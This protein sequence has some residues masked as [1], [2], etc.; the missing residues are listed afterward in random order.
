[1]LESN[2]QI[3]VS[4]SRSDLSFL[5]A[6]ETFTLKSSG[7]L[8]VARWPDGTM[9]LLGGGGGTSGYTNTIYECDTQ[10]R[11]VMLATTTP[12][13]VGYAGAVV[14]P[15]GDTLLFGGG[16]QTEG[17]SQTSN[18]YW[19]YSR[20]AN[21][22]TAIAD[23]SSYQPPTMTISPDGA[24]VYLL[25]EPT[26]G[27]TTQFHRVTIATWAVTNLTTVDAYGYKTWGCG[28]DGGA[29]VLMVDGGFYGIFNTDTRRFS[30]S[31][32]T[33]PE[34]SFGNSDIA[35]LIDGRYVYAIQN[36]TLYRVDVCAH[37]WTSAPVR[38]YTG[39]ARMHWWDNTGIYT[40]R[41]GGVYDYIPFF[42]TENPAKRK[43]LHWRIEILANNGGTYSEMSEVELLVN[44]V[45]VSSGAT[46]SQSSALNTSVEADKLI[47]D[48]TATKWVSTNADRGNCSVS[49][50]LTASARV[51]QVAITSAE[52]G[53]T[54]SSPNRINIFNSWDG[55]TWTAIRRFKEQTG[56]S[57]LERRVFTLSAY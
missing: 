55:V 2:E 1:M 30:S 41:T 34:F 17:S 16:R 19:R 6:T 12:I 22:W 49:F 53:A 43:C 37:E 31:Y 52:T 7:S 44:G 42:Q 51:T 48:N 21:T 46:T 32:P 56:W 8:A 57:N 40:L 33:P 26:G 10:G 35:G 47:D 29:Y 28:M 54:L 27:T 23:I 24:S 14:L 11:L 39:R 38:D 5:T 9:W 20:S 15:D 36:G 18:N 3:A 45:D 4:V 13:N 25:G 50:Q